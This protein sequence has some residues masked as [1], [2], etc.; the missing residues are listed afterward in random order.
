MF[1]ITLRVETRVNKSQRIVQEIL[2][3]NPLTLVGEESCA[4][5]EVESFIPIN[6]RRRRTEETA[7]SNRS[8]PEIARLAVLQASSPNRPEEA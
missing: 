6:Q 2:P 8:A 3:N 5:R 1:G 4:F 7:Q